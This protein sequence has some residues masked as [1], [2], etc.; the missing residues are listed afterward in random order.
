MQ[1][2]EKLSTPQP[3]LK[4]HAPRQPLRSHT[5]YTITERARNFNIGLASQSLPVISWLITVTLEICRNE[6]LLQSCRFPDSFSGAQ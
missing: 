4:L 1:V 2:G 6:T 5:K 3:G